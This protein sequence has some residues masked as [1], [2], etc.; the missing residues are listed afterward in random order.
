MNFE[1]FSVM[2]VFLLIL[3]LFIG[4][5]AVALS[6]IKEEW[7]SRNTYEQIRNDCYEENATE[8]AYYECRDSRYYEYDREKA[9]V[10]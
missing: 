1:E 2:V 3:V 9:I 4:G 10:D 6:A 8:E 5:A 7:I